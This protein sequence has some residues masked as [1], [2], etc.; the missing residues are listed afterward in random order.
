MT[1]TTVIEI[2]AKGVKTSPVRVAGGMLGVRRPPIAADKE[3]LWRSRRP[4]WYATREAVDRFLSLCLEPQDSAA[5]IRRLGKRDRRRLMLAVL[6]TRGCESDWR[7]LYGSPLGLDER[8]FAVMIW[9]RRREVERLQK[10][11]LEMREKILASNKDQMHKIATTLG[12]PA[13]GRSKSPAAGA[14]AEERFKPPSWLFGHQLGASRILEGILGKAAI[15]PLAK[16]V[17]GLEALGS[18]TLD[19]GIKAQ[20]DKLE[21]LPLGFTRGARVEQALADLPGFLGVKARPLLAEALMPYGKG[22]TFSALKAFQGRYELPWMSG[23]PNSLLGSQLKS[24][25]DSP[26][27]L[28]GGRGLEYLQALPGMQSFA[29]E[30]RALLGES[31]LPDLLPAIGGRPAGLLGGRFRSYLD[32]FGRITQPLIAA[33]EFAATW[34]EDPLWFLLGVLSPRHSALLLEL[35]REQVYEATFEALDHTVRQTSL[36]DALKASIREVSYL[37]DEQRQWLRHGLDHAK[38]GEWVQAV[39]PLILGLEG[40]LHAAAVEARVIRPKT[41]G[42]HIKANKVIRI[43]N[44]SQDFKAF[45]GK[46]VFSEEGHAFRHGQPRSDPRRHSL[47]LVVAVIGWLDHALGTDANHVLAD[48]MGEPLSIAVRSYDEDEVLAAP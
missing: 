37:S 23:V 30:Q 38:A 7:R 18:T 31:I 26:G 14:L 11:L 41:R 43:I 33:A 32:Q 47:L 2:E 10:T 9:A 34:G 20:M 25:I 24:L 6:R 28:F 44:V 29:E 17:F 8:F 39:P 13:I 5:V 4:G 36:I 27:Q 48:E 46:L 21:V 1:M 42:K 3:L 22:T 12:A 35:G 15:T 16:G 45:V 19:F 40:A